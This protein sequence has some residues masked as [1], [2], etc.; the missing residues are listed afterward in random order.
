MSSETEASFNST[1]ALILRKKKRTP[2]PCFGRRHHP[3]GL[4]YWH[5]F[6]FSRN[7]KEARR[8][9]LS[10]HNQDCTATEWAARRQKL[11]DWTSQVSVS[12]TNKH[13]QVM[14]LPLI[15]FQPQSLQPSD[16][17]WP[18]LWNNRLP[19]KWH[20]LLGQAVCVRVCITP[21]TWLK[22]R[23]ITKWSNPLWPRHPAAACINLFNS[24]NKIQVP[25]S[26]FYSSTHQIMS[27]ST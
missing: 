2:Q 27:L 22:V 12:W 26:L 20:S 15:S 4:P 8:R 23:I 3:S 10:G 6:S 5:A 24:D 1:T 25:Q 16:S 21:A 13:S 7:K 9:E 18:T 14:P 19:K 17:L 11:V